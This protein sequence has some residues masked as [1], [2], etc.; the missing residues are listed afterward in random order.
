MKKNKKTL[1][2]GFT[3]FAAAILCNLNWAVNDY[4][5]K[6]ISLNPRILAQTGTKGTEDGTGD[7]TETEENK[8]GYKMKQEDCSCNVTGA[9]G[10]TVKLGWLVVTIKGKGGAH[11]NFNNAQTLCSYG[12]NLVSCKQMTC[13]EF[14][15]KI[16]TPQIM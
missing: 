13:G 1:V 2:V 5:M 10:T 6:E 3:L 8:K 16:G 7:G 4:G 14:W 12:G 11:F 9:I 15:L